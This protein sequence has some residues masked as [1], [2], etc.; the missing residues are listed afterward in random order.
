M[1][2]AQILSSVL[3]AH[4]ISLIAENDLTEDYFPTYKAEYD[5]LME[6]YRDYSVMPD[7][8]TFISQFP[9]FPYTVVTEPKEYLLK[10]IREEHQYS[11]MVPVINKW[12][13]LM[14]GDAH[15]AY[16]YIVSALPTLV[17]SEGTKGVDIIAKAKDRYDE[18]LERANAEDM[19]LIP[20]GF[21]E[22]DELVG[23]FNRGEEFVVILART[24]EGK[25]WIMLK[26]L[27][28]AWKNGLRVGLLEPEMSYN[29]IGYRF[30]TIHGNISNTLMVRGKDDTGKKYKEYINSLTEVK[31]PF[32][33]AI[34]KDFNRDVTVP[35]LKSFCEQN[36]LDVLG[37]D[38]ISYLK[39]SRGK[40]TDNKTTTLTNISEDLMDLSI[41]LGIPVLAV[42]QSNRTG[43]D[44][45]GGPGLESIRD[46]DGI[47]YN[48][49]MVISIK[50]KEPGLELSLKK[51]RN[52]SVGDNLTYV[53]DIDKGT[54]L[55]VPAETDSID[56]TEQIESQRKRFRDR[57]E[58]L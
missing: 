16:D 18:Y 42:V 58:A 11:L 25:T 1:V 48:A 55:Y 10:T 9:D 22:L 12:A 24:G 28:S 54:F 32:I 13:D 2:E 47:A 34:P 40:K 19:F 17:V 14:Q 45:N 51:N 57:R 53:W 7:V 41:E 4:D 3:R 49:S 8:E 23:G 30:D 29:K 39:D 21:P 35:K 37:I 27:E 38:G 15:A 43:V 50:Q 52:G 5:Y 36:K 56:N 26:M 6:H 33:V 31:N 46:S 20:T 44:T